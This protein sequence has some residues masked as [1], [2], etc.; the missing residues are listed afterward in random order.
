MNPRGSQRRIYV[1]VCAYVHEQRIKSR[2]DDF[3][4]LS[5]LHMLHFLFRA[6]RDCGVQ[7]PQDARKCVQERSNEAGR[8]DRNE[9]C[10]CTFAP[11]A[12]ACVCVFFRIVV[13]ATADIPSMHSAASAD[14]SR[15]YCSDLQHLITKNRRMCEHLVILLQLNIGLH[16]KTVCM[17]TPLASC[18]VATSLRCDELVCDCD[19]DT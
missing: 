7:P 2:G 19:R 11:D 5:S 13:C 18:K 8:R 3:H 1:D 16:N 4:R 14:T 6:E 10:N 12:S 9:F 15:S 17:M